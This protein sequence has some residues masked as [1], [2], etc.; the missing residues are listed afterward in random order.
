MRTLWYGLLSLL[1]SGNVT[2]DHYVIGVEDLKYL[3]YYHYDNGTYSGYGRDLLDAFATAKGHR[4]EYRAL[5]IRRLYS[6]FLS[7]NLD[8]K[9]P[10]NPQWH[11]EERKGKNIQ[12]SAAMID[13]VDGTLVLPERKGGGFG[14][15]KSLAM[16]RGFTP[17]EYQDQIAARRLK[18][19]E[20]DNMDALIQ[21]TLQR[22][23]DGS[24]FNIVVA[25][26]YL[27]KIMNKPDA[28][29]FDP[30]LPYTRSHYLLSTLKHSELLLEFND[31]L[32][33]NPK[34]IEQL[35]RKWEVPID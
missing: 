20:V 7:G 19:A 32:Q 35:K 6:E 2:A 13:F 11:V 17:L 33:S 21:L 22:R 16:I 10:D 3:P 18:T 26:R 25:S 30:S 1:L 34:L 24:Y 9:F 14:K 15:L 28:L 5:P 12:Y 4:F 31:F 27:G 29:L 23:T 8:F